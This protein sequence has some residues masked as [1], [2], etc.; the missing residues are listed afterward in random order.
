MAGIVP[1]TLSCVLAVT[2]A[3]NFPRETMFALLMQEGG[4]EGQCVTNTNKTRDCGPYQIND[5]NI[6]GVAKHFGIGEGEARERVRDD[7]CFNAHAAGFL[8]NEHWRNSGDIWTAIGYYNSKTPPIAQ[9]YRTKVFKQ[10]QRLYV[11]PLGE[12]KA[13]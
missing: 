10:V 11:A 13:K 6:P 1:L 12:Q 8:L 7:G 4:K 5:I 9:T 3:Y 2:Q